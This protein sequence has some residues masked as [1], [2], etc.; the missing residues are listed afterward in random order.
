MSQA[1]YL[2]VEQQ[3]QVP[4]SLPDLLKELSQKYQLDIYQCRQRLL[5]RGLSLLHQGSRKGL[6]KVSARLQEAGYLH[7]LLEPT[8]PKFVPA[9]LRGLQITQGEIRLI[10]QNKT[11]AIPRGARILAL[12]AELSGVLAEQNVKQLLS[13]HAYRGRDDVRYLADHKI[14]KTILQGQPV[15]DIYLL[16]ESK[17]IVDGVRV[18]PGKFD[19]RGLGE[20]ATAS[21]KQNLDRVLKLTEEY[22]GDFHLQTDF[23]LVNLPG[24]TLRKDDKN[25]LEQQRQNLISLARYG[26]LMAD[27]QRVDP[28]RPSQAEEQV[29]LAGSVAAAVLLQNPTLAANGQLEQVMPVAREIAREVDQVQQEKPRVNTPATAEPGLPPPPTAARE[30]GLHTKPFF[31]VGVAGMA[32]PFTLMYFA[33]AE[34]K[35]LGTIFHYLFATGAA[36]LGLAGLMFW[37]GFYY[38]RLKRQI[39]NTPTSKVRSV[40]MGMVEVKGR[41]I[42]QY[43]LISPM[44]HVPCVFYRLTKYHRQNNRQWAVTSISSSDNVPFILEDDTGQVSIDPAGCK[45]RAGTRQEGAPGQVGLTRFDDCDDKWVE[46]IIVE[47]TLLYVLGHASVKREDGPTLNERKIEALRE[48]KRNPQNLQQFDTDGDGRISEDEWDAARGAVEEKVLHDSLKE[49]QRR[50][51][52]EEHV[53]IGKKQGRPL[54]IAE[55]HSEAKLTSRFAAYT[56]PLFIGAAAATGWSLYLLINYIR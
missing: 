36:P 55:T 10:C 3:P 54:V 5:G 32:L 53:V 1:S 15:L 56:I 45:V 25:N 31:W 2:I 4:E 40:A 8:K 48:L 16:D 22:A 12:F 21:S 47:G 26:W 27:L 35:V 43:A 44:S 9:R 28:I 18:F 30:L 6:E 13:S 7:W 29:D 17:Q 34:R 46:E 52:Q 33:G 20:R 19:H 42:R 38:I 11:M 39:E 50:K 14:Y 51:K 37:G 49:K 41:A 24:C 23:G